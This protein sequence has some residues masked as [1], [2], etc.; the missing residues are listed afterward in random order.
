M[1]GMAGP[2]H[3]GVGSSREGRSGRPSLW[4]NRSTGNPMDDHGPGPAGPT[5]RSAVDSGSLTC[6]FRAGSVALAATTMTEP[7]ELLSHLNR[8]LYAEGA[9]AGPATAIVARYQPH[10]TTMTLAQAGHLAPLRTR[11]GHTTERGQPSCDVRI[12]SPLGGIHRQQ[13]R[14]GRPWSI[15][16]ERE[17]TAVR[18]RPDLTDAVA[19][20]AHGGRHLRIVVDHVQTASATAMPTNAAPRPATTLA[21][22]FTKA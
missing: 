1:P 19:L 16:A 21:A 15:A 14:P 13:R 3:P 10:T 9:H 6:P 20:A 8:L 12:A 17:A 7:D 2:G 4:P 22:A 11:G 18:R 5:I